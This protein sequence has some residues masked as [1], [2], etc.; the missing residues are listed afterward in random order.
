MGLNVVGKRIFQD[1]Q[2]YTPK[3]LQNLSVQIQS[4]NCR[5]V[6]TTEKDMIKIPEIF[7]NKF[8]FYVVKIT[9][10]FKDDSI[11]IKKIKPIFLNLS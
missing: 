11:M 7:L 10:V 6:I 3:I 1:H 5:A 2:K 4:T 9:I 8:I